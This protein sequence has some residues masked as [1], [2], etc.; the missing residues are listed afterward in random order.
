[1]VANDLIAHIESQSDSQW[2]YS[3]YR[4]DS[5]VHT[6]GTEGESEKCNFPKGVCQFVGERRSRCVIGEAA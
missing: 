2:T 5:P 3:K 4:G 6:L 1:V